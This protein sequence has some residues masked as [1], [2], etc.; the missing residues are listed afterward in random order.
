MRSW[1]K[2]ITSQ[3]STGLCAYCTNGVFTFL[4]SPPP[5]LLVAMFL[6]LV[7]RLFMARVSREH[8]RISIDVTMRRCKK[9]FISQVSTG[10]CA[11]C[12]NSMFTFLNS[13][14]HQLLVAM[15]LALVQRLFRSRFS[16]EL[17]RISIDGT[18][19]RWRKWI[20]S[21]VPTFLCA[22]CT[23]GVFTFLRSPHPQ[24]LV[25]MFLALEQRLFKA[26]FSRELA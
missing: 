2:W 23:N 17:A 9:L 1:R 8:A 22:F 7:Q 10:L 16:R 6:T 18:M 25:A 3:V 26:R 15:L 20:S 12:T 5:Q 14:L 13:P 11:F 4:R 21:Q 24:L 19:R